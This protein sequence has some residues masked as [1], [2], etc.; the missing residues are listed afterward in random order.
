[1]QLNRGKILYISLAII[2]CAVLATVYAAWQASRFH[3][4]STN[5]PISSVPYIFPYM[6]INC[7]KTLVSTGL[8]VSTSPNIL[9]GY[10]VN[11]KTLRLNLISM[12]KDKEYQ[13]F[14][15]HL[16]S[17]DGKILN[18]TLRFKAKD[19]PF[20][21][22]TKDQ[23]Q[24]IVNAQDPND[25]SLLT[26]DPLVSHLPYGDLGY[27]ISYVITTKNNEPYLQIEISVILAG[28]DY[29]LDSQA[30]QN[31]INQRE[32]AALD[33]IKSLGLNPLKYNIK[34]SVP[35]H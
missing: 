3:I 19:I 9:K 25:P 6:D 26:N 31:T 34:Y 1:M 14:I 8:S 7:N 13:I 5:P 4:V 29:K 21:S 24:A 28:S 20:N 10:S 16:Q 33:Y 27:N 18:K 11:G 15:T 30:L 32:Q 17:V 35:S 22:L 23:Q 12:T 2:L